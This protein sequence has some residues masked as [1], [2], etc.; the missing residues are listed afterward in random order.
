MH[1]LA[2]T[3]TCAAIATAVHAQAAPDAAAV[4]AAERAFAADSARL[5][6]G[7][8]FNLWAAPEAIVIGQQGVERVPDAYLPTTSRPADEPFLEWWPTFAGM[9][10]SGDF[11][12]STG[13]VRVDGHR[14]GHYLTVWK[15][16]ADGSWKWIYDGGTGASAVDVPGP[17]AEPVI[18][19]PGS[20]TFATPQDDP[21]DKALS[22]PATAMDAVRAQEARLAVAAATDQKA[23]HLAVLADN[24]RLYVGH[25]PPAMGRDAFAQALADW[26]EAI[27]FGPT[28]GGDASAGG[29]LV[30][31]YG[32][33]GWTSEG[34][35]R[36]GHYVRL[37][38]R[39]G[40]GWR[41]VLAQLIP[42]A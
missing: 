14:R 42:T 10:R 21:A 32:K 38:Q 4:V 13:G 33:A 27:R 8:S 35:I 19:P 7:G 41:I 22:G 29:D 28:E 37:W 34:R 6:I 23:A 39:Q 20:D 40:V 17:E 18:L 36:E 2:L 30:W 11:G 26:P 9:S 15:K 5:G 12:F 31:T 25:R 3:I 24:G 16:Q 1:K